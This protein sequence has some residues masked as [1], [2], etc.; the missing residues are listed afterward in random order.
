MA[1]KK[2]DRQKTNEIGRKTSA[3]M[4]KIDA[5]FS[6]A[7]WYSCCIRRRGQEIAFFHVSLKK[8]KKEIII[9]AE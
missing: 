2:S 1:K 7:I 8:K 6:A 4:R 5:Y 3:K 9:A